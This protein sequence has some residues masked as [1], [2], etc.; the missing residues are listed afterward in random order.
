MIE[1]LIFSV[2]NMNQNLSIIMFY[3]IK[4]LQQSVCLLLLFTL[5]TKNEFQKQF[6]VQEHKA[7]FLDESTG[8]A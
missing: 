8:H 2:S 4:S 1:L 7:E 6:N 3:N 5:Q